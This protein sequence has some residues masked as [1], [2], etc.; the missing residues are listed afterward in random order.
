MFSL[1]L[2]SKGEKNEWSR[3]DATVGGPNRLTQSF[4]VSIN[5]KGGYCWHVYMQVCFSLMA[6]SEYAA[7][8][9]QGQRKLKRDSA[10]V[11]EECKS[12]LVYLMGNMQ[13]RK[14][15][16][17][18]I[19]AWKYQK[20]KLHFRLSDTR[21]LRSQELRLFNTGVPELRNL[22]NRNP[23][24]GTSTRVLQTRK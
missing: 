21:R 15:N 17:A 22:E 24:R 3:P 5:A 4:K 6:R 9:K 13:A 11:H 1:T 20:R 10:E 12:V 2:M 16:N 7:M 14:T 19:I 23:E 8:E 18:R